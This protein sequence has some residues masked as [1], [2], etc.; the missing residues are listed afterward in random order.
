MLGFQVFAILSAKRLR[1]GKKRGMIA[2]KDVMDM[3][4]CVIVGG[5]VEN[6]G[7]PEYKGVTGDGI[8]LLEFVIR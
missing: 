1:P 7:F 6:I 2:E 8:S 4:R 3:R 5:P